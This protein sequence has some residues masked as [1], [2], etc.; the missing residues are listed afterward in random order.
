SHTRH[1]Q[2]RP[3]RSPRGRSHH[4]PDGFARAHREARLPLL[5]P[6]PCE[7]APVPFTSL[8][9]DPRL[10]EGLRDLGYAE[11]RPIQTAVIPLALAGHDLI[12]C[13]ETGTGKTAAFVV[14]I[15]QG[16]LT[17]AGGPERP[18]VQT[19]GAPENPPLQIDGAPDGARPFRGRDGAGKS[20]VL[21]LAPTRELAVQ[22]EDEIH[23]LSYHTT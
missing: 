9:L 19:P 3:R 22:I 5:E 23:G 2:R 16:L 11:T 21:V 14:P 15:L 8:T 20:R 12:G 18:A 13:A 17:A 1:P 7:T 10:L 6:T 4:K